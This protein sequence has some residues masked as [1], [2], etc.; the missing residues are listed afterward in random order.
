MTTAD[1]LEK[2]ASPPDKFRYMSLDEVAE[3]VDGI[4]NDTY[5]E[6]WKEL[7][8]A[9]N[10]KPPGGDGSDGTTGEPI[11]SDGSYG[12]DLVAAWG[13][14]SARARRNIHACAEDNDP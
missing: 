6:L 13:R 12:S 14:L 5:T 8:S 10:R 2:L 1:D 9:D 7:E 4:T 11:V 3:T